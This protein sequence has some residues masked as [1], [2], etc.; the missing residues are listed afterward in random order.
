MPLV[1]LDPE[2]LDGAVKVDPDPDP[3]APPA[4]LPAAVLVVDDVA[5]DRS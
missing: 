4:V 5:L 3:N 2:R 1:E